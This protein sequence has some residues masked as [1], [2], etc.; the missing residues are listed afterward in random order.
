MANHPSAAKRY[1]QSLTHRDRNRDQR[2]AIREQVLKALEAVKAGNKDGAKKEL[3]ATERVLA[4]AA[5]KGLV[6]KKN[7]ARRVGR[8]AKRVSAMK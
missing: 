1:R 6:H 2:R 7:A 8:L 3:H 4:K 5:Q